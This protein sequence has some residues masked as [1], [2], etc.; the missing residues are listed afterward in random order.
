[1]KGQVAVSISVLLSMCGFLGSQESAAY[2]ERHPP[3]P[4]GKPV[5]YPALKAEPVMKYTT[6]V[7]EEGAVRISISR[8]QKERG[9]VGKV[10][11]T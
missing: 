2:P 3:F 6:G 1:M 9:K 8:G 11:V 10:T 7:F 5:P 4:A